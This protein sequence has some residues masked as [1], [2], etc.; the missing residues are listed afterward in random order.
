MS[1]SPL[2]GTEMAFLNKSI[3]LAF[4][5]KV[6]GLL[7]CQLI[8]TL[9]FVLPLTFYEPAKLFV[10]ENAYLIIIAFVLTFVTMIAMVCCERVR[11]TSPTNFIF[12]SIFTVAEGFL[13]GVV[14]ASYNAQ[15]VVIAL[16]ICI[17]ICFSLTMFAFQTKIDFTAYGGILLVALIVLMLYGFIMMLFPYS[18]TANTIYACLGAFI[19]GIYLVYDTQLMIGGNH[20]YSISPE[21]Y[22]FATLNIYLD[23]INMFLFIL[24]IIGTRRD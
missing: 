19:F 18:R 16:A 15:E 22:I 6:Y 9:F 24:Q 2:I 11:R 4:V 7:M 21:E 17:I 10:T 12:L 1:S 20:K 14:S 13:V 5:R 3:Q 23:I 8:V